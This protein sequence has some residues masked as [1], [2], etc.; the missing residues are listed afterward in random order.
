MTL[1]ADCEVGAKI[2]GLGA[3][4]RRLSQLTDRGFFLPW[5]AY[6]TERVTHPRSL[7]SK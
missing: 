3:V 2:D 4:S 6:L 7:K 1:L 5:L